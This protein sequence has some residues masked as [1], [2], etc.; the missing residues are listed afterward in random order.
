MATATVPPV[1]KALHAALGAD[2]VI[3]QYRDPGPATADLSAGQVEVYFAP[4]V[5]A[6][7]HVQA[8]RLRA[9]E[10][11]I[12]TRAEALPDVPTI[13][14]FVSG[15]EGSNWIGVGAPR[16]TPAEI[17][18]KLNSEI[19]GALTAPKIK[20]RLADLGAAAVRG[21]V[22]D[23]RKFIADDTEKWGK[24]IRAANIKVE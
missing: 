23:F 22:D 3:V 1:L 11:T 16:T 8:G 14:E 9:L 12:T 5:Q 21:S 13:G 7:E 15:Y 19:N 10:V 24:I 20:A 18:A 2:L 4:L 17:V 6:V